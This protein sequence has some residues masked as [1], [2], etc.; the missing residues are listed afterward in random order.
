MFSM[1][2]SIRGTFKFVDYESGTGGGSDEYSHFCYII[3]VFLI[4]SSVYY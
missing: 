2:V 3:N 4:H 1:E